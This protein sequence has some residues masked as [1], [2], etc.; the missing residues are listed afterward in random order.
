MAAAQAASLAAS[1]VEVVTDSR[2]VSGGV[3]ALQGGARPDEWAHAD[4]WEAVA[5]R[6]R[7]GALTARWVRSHLDEAAL[8]ERG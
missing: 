4:L 1:P 7:D 5:P 3:A 2:F 6:C 8:L